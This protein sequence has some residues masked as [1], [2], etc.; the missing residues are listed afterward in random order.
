MTTALT[1]ITL[2]NPFAITPSLLTFT[3]TDGAATFA[4]DGMTFLIAQNSGAGATITV[5]SV[6]A[7]RT[8][9]T[10]DITTDAIAGGGTIRIYQVFSPSGWR[11]S[12]GLVNV[13]VSNVSVALAACRIAST[14]QFGGVN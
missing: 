1:V 9:R 7:P 8:G 13:T 5:S 11:Q 14:P 12:T 4:C 10:G 2:P 3:T 6:A